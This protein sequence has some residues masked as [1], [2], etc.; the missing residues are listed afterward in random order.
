MKTFKHVLLIDNNKMDSYI[1]DR[2]LS[3]ANLIEKITF[4]N[5]A[6]DALKYL[7]KLQ[8]NQE[9]FPD[10][11]FLDIHMP[12]IDG[13]GFLNEFTNNKNSQ[14]DSCS[15]IMLT[16]S[17]DPSDVARAMQYPIVKKHLNKPL[18]LDILKCL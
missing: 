18:S 7:N 2:F 10:L 8:Q 17:D 1:E 3:K 4:M 5:P 13:F 11:I 14:P 16:S 6:S 15:V 9:E 12:I